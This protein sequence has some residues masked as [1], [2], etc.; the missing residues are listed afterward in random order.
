MIAIEKINIKDTPLCAFDRIKDSPFSFFLDSAIASNKL[1]RYSFMGER[2][3]LVF[4]SKKDNITLDWMTKRETVKGNPFLVLKK[5]LK[6]FHIDERADL[7][8]IG[9]GVGYFSYDLKDFNERLPDRAI[10][11]L[12]IPDCMICFYDTILAFDHLKEEWLA[13][14]SGPSRQKA[15]LE[16]LKERISVCKPELESNFT[17]DSYIKTVLKAKEYI[18]KGDI[19]QVNLSQRF[20]VKLERDPWELYGILRKINPAPFASFL[21]FGDIKIVSASPERFLKIR[22]RHI[23]TRPIKGTRPRG[24]TPDED[25]RLRKDL[26]SSEKDRAENLMIIDLERNDLGRVS[27]YGSVSVQE[28]MSCEEYATVFHLT[29]AVQGKLRKNIDSM[30]CFMNCFPGGSITG[31][32]K[33]RSMEIIEELEPVKR[34]IYTGSI[35]YIGFNGNIDTSIVIRTLV[36]KG[37]DAYFHVGGGIVHDSDPVREYQ[38]TLDKARALREALAIAGNHENCVSK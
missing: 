8:F 15:R 4:K 11:D 3:F 35:G 25:A 12:N 1:G 2:P 18:K 19:Y 37:N 21:N 33:I 32:P 29:S 34:G 9:G 7:P 16:S 27:E 38:E 10:D 31:A 28:F 17:R 36:I 24:K 13:I 30:D 20:T 14:S 26:T 23:E 5:L 22:G 6:S